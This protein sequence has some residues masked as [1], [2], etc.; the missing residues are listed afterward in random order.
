MKFGLFDHIDRA[1]DRPLA[2]QFDERIEF[3]RRQT[4]PGFTACMLQSITPHL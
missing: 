1:D 4:E 3:V 2:Q